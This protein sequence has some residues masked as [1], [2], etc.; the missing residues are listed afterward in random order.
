RQRLCSFGNP[1]GRCFATTS[2]EPSAQNQ[3]NLTER[4]VLA[5]FLRLERRELIPN[6]IEFLPKLF[7]LF[8]GIRGWFFVFQLAPPLLARLLVL[9][10][11]KVSPQPVCFNETP[12]SRDYQKSNQRCK[13]KCERRPGRDEVQNPGAPGRRRRG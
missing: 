8:P 9:S 2:R 4:R 6:A 10:L 3:R 11:K 13:P 5:G 12:H 7:V 1:G